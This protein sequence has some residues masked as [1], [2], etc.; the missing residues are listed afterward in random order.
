MAACERGD[1]RLGGLGECG[2]EVEL[3]ECLSRTLVRETRAF[4]KGD[5]HAER[6]EGRYRGRKHGSRDAVVLDIAAACL[7]VFTSM[8]RLES[9][10]DG[11]LGMTAVCSSSPESRESITP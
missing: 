4:C 1:R 8:R 5:R 9:R 3:L 10:D 2:T 11:T 6:S 7:M